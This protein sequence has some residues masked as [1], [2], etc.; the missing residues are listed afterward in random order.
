MSC[1]IQPARHNQQP[2][3][4]WGTEGV[5]KAL[6]KMTKNANF[7]PNLVVLGTKNQ[8]FTG[9]SKSLGTHLTEKPPMHLVRTVFCLAWDQMGQ[10]ANI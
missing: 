8:F 7:G 5:S 9:G 2:T 10:N 6:P 4:Q 3:H 1:D